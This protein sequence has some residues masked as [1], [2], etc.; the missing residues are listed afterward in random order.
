VKN[1]K[2]RVT[3]L[4]LLLVVT[5]FITISKV[6]ATTEFV[7]DVSDVW[8]NGRY[9]SVI[10][11]D[12]GTLYYA[13]QDLYGNLSG[14]GNYKTEFT[15]IN[16][17]D[18]FYGTGKE[19]I[20]YT[21]ANESRG[22]LLD[23]EGN[24]YYASTYDGV[25]YDR[26]FSYCVRKDNTNTCHSN[27]DNA[28]ILHPIL[29]KF[30]EEYGK[31]IIRIAGVR[32]A[33]IFETEDHV[34]WGIGN[35]SEE[36]VT[37][38][39]LGSG[40]VVLGSGNTIDKSETVNNKTVHD[41][42]MLVSNVQEWKIGFFD[43]A[44][45]KDA[46]SRLWFKANNKWYGVGSTYYNQLLTN[47][48]YVGFLSDSDFNGP[49]NNY[50]KYGRALDYSKINQ[51]YNKNYSDDN[52]VSIEGYG[53]STII[54]FDDGIA[55]H[56]GLPQYCNIADSAGSACLG[57][58][59]TN[60]IQVKM[61]ASQDYKDEIGQ[62][63]DKIVRTFPGAHAIFIQT[64]SGRIWARGSNDEGDLGFATDTNYTG[65][66]PYFTDISDVSRTGQ[67]L[68]VRI[69][70]TNGLKQQSPI[71]IMNPKK[72]IAAWNG[73]IA[74]RND[75]YLVGTARQGTSAYSGYY[76]A[77]KYEFDYDGFG[78]TR[79]KRANRI[80][81][82][83]TIIV[84]G[85]NN[86]TYW[87]ENPS[88]LQIGD[89]TE[90]VN[91]EDGKY[92]TYAQY[93]IYGCG[94]SVNNYTLKDISKCTYEV[95]TN[96]SNKSES[97]TYDS[98]IDDANKID[99]VNLYNVD[100][101]SLNLSPGYYKLVAKRYAFIGPDGTNG[102][103]PTSN[104]NA[105]KL[106]YN[107]SIG[108]K[109]YYFQFSVEP[110]IEAD[111][112]TLNVGDTFNEQDNVIATNSKGLN[113]SFGNNDYDLKVTSNNV[114]TNKVGV[115]FVSY[116]MKDEHVDKVVTKTIRVIV[117]DSN[118]IIS[119][120][121]L[122]QAH[123]YVLNKD[124]DVVN[125][126]NNEILNNAEA[127]A[128]LLSDGSSVDVKVIN[129]DNYHNEVN[130]YR[131]TI[132][133]KDDESITKTI[134]ASII[135]NDTT[136]KD[137]YAIKG[138]DFTI[139]SKNVGDSSDFYNEN[140]GN[141]KIWNIED[142]NDVVDITSP[143]NYDGYSKNENLYNAQF[144]IKNGT[145]NALNIKALV[146]D[147]ERFVDGNNYVI[148][149][150]NVVLSL[151]DAKNI[152]D[153]N[154]FISLSN[155]KA[156][157]KNDFSNGNIIVDT[158][159]SNFN[160][161]AGDYTITFIVQEE[162]TTK[163]SIN[164]KVLDYD[165][166]TSNDDY[167]L[168]ANDFDINV[169]RVAS[170][171]D[172]K[173]K[174]QSS[175][176]I[177]DK[178]FN[179]LNNEIN[180]SKNDIVAQVGGP[181]E[182]IFNIN[183]TNV[184]LSIMV[185]VVK[186]DN[187]VLNIPQY[188][189][190]MI[191]E[192]FDKFK[193]VSISDTEDGVISPN[194][195]NVNISGIIDTSKPGVSLLTYSFTDSDNNTVQATTLLIVD[196]GTFT[197]NDGYVLTAH[198]FII[199]K[200]DIS[201]D[202]NDIL[203][204]SQAHAYNLSDGHEVNVVVYNKNNYSN[205]TT[206]SEVNLILAVQ[207]NNNAKK[208][209]KAT[210]VDKDV[211]AVG[212]NYSIGANNIVIGKNDVNNLSDNELL[213]LM[214][215]EAWQVND[216]S[217]KGTVVIEDKDNIQ[218]IAGEYHF[219]LNVKEEATTKLN[220]TVEVSNKDNY[221]EDNG[222]IITSNDIVIGKK[223]VKKLDTD[224]KI[225][226]AI[227]A[228][229]IK[230]SDNSEQD[231]VILSDG[232]LSDLAM[233]YDITFALKDNQ[234]ITGVSAI[235]V[236]DYDHSF[237]N[238]NYQINAND[239]IKVNTT[240]VEDILNSNSEAK[241][242]NLSEAIAYKNRA[243]I[244]PTI[245][246]DYALLQAK[247]GTY[248]VKFYIDEDSNVYVIADVVVD[249][250]N[251][252]T[253]NVN[254]RD[255]IMV[256]SDYDPL[257]NVSVSDV[258]DSNINISD[259]KVTW[260]KPFNKDEVGLY[261]INYEVVDSDN[262]KAVA[263]RILCVNDGSIILG[264]D[265][266]LQA[267]DFEENKS[268]A[269][270]DANHI[271]NNSH[272]KAFKLSD[273][274]EEEV[275]V[276]D[277]GTYDD[278]KVGNHSLVLAIKDESST[279]KDINVVVFDSDNYV[280][281]DNY[282]IMGNNII[283]G[284]ND[285]SSISDD[286]IISYSKAK[287]W[288]NTHFNDNSLAID[289]DYHNLQAKAGTYDVI[290]AVHDH[291]DVK[292]TIKVT[293]LDKDIVNQGANYVISGDNAIIGKS[294][295]Q[296][297]SSDNDFILLN[298][299]EAFN[300]RD[301]NTKVDVFVDSNYFYNT[302]GTYEVKYCIKDE[303]STC[304]S[305]SIEVVDYDHAIA[306]DN[307]YLKANDV[308]INLGEVSGLTD[309]LFINKLVAD[310]NG[311]IKVSDLSNIQNSK[312]EYYVHIYLDEANNV[313]LKIKVN[314]TNGESP[315]LSFNSPVELKVNDNFDVMDGVSVS[316]KED[317]DAQL[318]NSVV[319]DKTSIDTSK[320]GL[321]ILNYSVIDSDFNEVKKP[322]VVLV[323]DGS[324]IVGDK[325]ILKAT[326]F[327]IN[328]K[329]VSLND[330]DIIKQASALGYTLAVD[331]VNGNEAKVIILDKNDYQ[332][333]P[334][335]YTI[336]FGV[337]DNSDIKASKDINATVIDKDYLVTGNS[338]MIAANDITLGLDDVDNLNEN[339]IIDLAQ[340][341]AWNKN[342]YQTKSDVIVN[343]IDVIKK[344]ATFDRPYLVTLAVK[345][346]TNTQ[347]VIKVHVINKDVVV[348]NHDY[349]ISGN[350][351]VIGKKDAENL[352]V[353]DLINMMNVEA[354][355]QKTNNNMDVVLITSSIDINK[356]NEKQ[357]IEFKIKDNDIK[358]TLNLLIIDND[359][360]VQYDNYLLVADD[361][362][363]RISQA[364]NI[365][366]ND[367]IQF[368]KAKV[369]DRNSLSECDNVIVNN[370]NI[371]NVKGTYDVNLGIN[372][373]PNSSLSIKAN[374][375]SGSAPTIDFNSPIILDVND[376]FDVYDG[377]MINDADE[378]L[379]N[380]NVDI[381]GD[382]VDTSMSGIYKILY[383]L[384]DSD[385]NI[386]S[387]PRLVIV[388]GNGIVINQHYVLEAHS[389]IINAN[390]FSDDDASII[391]SSKAKAYNIDDLTSADIIVL[392]KNNYSAVSGKYPLKLAVK[393]D[394]SLIRDI[395]ALV[396]ANDNYYESS[397]YVITSNDVI[398]GLKT[399]HSIKN[400]QDLIDITNAQAFNKK[401]LNN[402]IVSVAS[403]DF[404]DVSGNYDVV[405][406]VDKEP[407]STINSK[408]R[409]IDK[410][411]VVVNNDYGIEGNDIT[412]GTKDAK[413][414]IDN[415]EVENK[416]IALAKARAWL[417]SDYDT[418]LSSLAIKDC[419]LE[420][421][422]GTY[423]A[424]VYLEDKVSMTININVIKDDYYYQ[425][426]AYTIIGNDFTINETVAKNITRDEII[427]LAKAKTY[428]NSDNNQLGSVKVLNN[429][430]KNQKE[431]TYQVKLYCDEEIDTFIIINVTI[432]NGQKPLLNISPEFE[433]VP[434]NTSNYDV[435]NG[436]SASDPD[437]ASINEN[438]VVIKGSVDTSQ[439]GIY[440]IN[441]SLT[442][443]DFNIVNKTRVVLV[444]DGSYIIGQNYIIK[445]HDFEI[446]KKYV[447][448]DL[449]SII[450]ASE[451]EAYSKL[452]GSKATVMV[453]DDDSY[454][455]KEIKTYHIKLAV[456]E[457]D[458]LTTSINATIFNKDNSHVNSSYSI[459]GN[460][461]VLAQDE[462]KNLTKEKLIDKAQLEQWDTG[463]YISTRDNNVVISDRE[464]DKINAQPNTYNIS[465]AHQKNNGI[466]ITIKVKV[467][468][469][470]VV[471]YDENYLIS[472]N[473]LVL[474]KKQALAISDMNEFISLMNV[475]GFDNKD[476]NVD[477]EVVTALNEFD[478][479]KNVQEIEFKVKDVI[480]PTIKVK[481]TILDYDY[482]QENNG[483]IIA[484]ND[485]SIRKS[486]VNNLDIVSKAKATIFEK[487][488]LTKPSTNYQVEIKQGQVNTDIKDYAI[489]LGIKD[490][491]EPTLTINVS[492]GAGQIPDLNVSPLVIINKDKNET[493]QENDISVSDQE[494][495]TNLN[496]IAS[497][498]NVNNQ[499]IGIYFRYYSVTDSDNNSV[500][501][502]RMIVVNDDKN[503]IIVDENKGYVLKADNYV[504]NSKDVIDN[505]FSQIITLSNAIAY[506]ISDAKQV[507]VIVSNSDNYNKNVGLYQ[508]IIA[509]KD[510]TSI[511]KK[512]NINVLNK[513]IIQNGNVYAIGAK[514]IKI[515]KEKARVLA[516]DNNKLIEALHAEAWQIKDYNQKGTV[517]VT[518]T[519]NLQ[520][521]VG[522]YDITLK[523]KEDSV[524]IQ[525]K[526]IVVDYDIYEYDDEYELMA[527]NIVIG[528]EDAKNISDNK[529]LLSLAD[530]KAIKL[531]DNSKA[532]VELD[533]TNFQSDKGSYQ[534]QISVKE[535]N[536]IKT[537]L[538][539]EV[540]DN[541]HAQKGNNYVIVGNDFTINTTK[542]S[543]IT[544]DEI[545][546]LAKANGYLANDVNQ[547]GNVIVI[548]NAI[549]GQEG[550]FSVVLGLQ[551]DNKALITIN[552][553]VTNGKAPILEVNNPIELKVN[554][555]FN[556]KNTITKLED[557]KDQLNKN[558][559]VI[560]GNV[561]TKV[562]GIY[563]LTY[564]VSDSDYNVTEVKQ[565]VI[566]ND[567][568]YLI[569]D[570]YV[571][572]ACDFSEYVDNTELSEN[573][574]LKE[575]K[576]YGYDIKNNK[577]VSVILYNINDYQAKAGKYTIELAL[578]N[579]NDVRKSQ[580]I[581]VKDLPQAVL[582]NVKDNY[583]LIKDH[584]F[585]L[586][587][588]NDDNVNI[589]LNS[590]N[591]DI[592]SVDNTGV[593]KGLNKGTSIIKIIVSTRDGLKETS[594]EV[595]I[596]VGLMFEPEVDYNNEEAIDA[597]N[598][599]LTLSETKDL[600][601]KLLINK[602]HASAW[603][604]NK[605]TLNDDIKVVVNNHK[606]KSKLSWDG[607][608]ALLSSETKDINRGYVYPITF[609][610]NKGT[611][612]TIYARVVPDQDNESSSE[613]I[614][615]NKNSNKGKK[616]IVNTGS[617]YLLIA[618]SLLVVSE[619]TYL[620]YTRQSK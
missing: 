373:I 354:I 607:K 261:R 221:L 510:D 63:W 242:I 422:E 136:I 549:V 220:I 297:L 382:T 528:K 128:F 427:N 416:I 359:Y 202:D 256:G 205:V 7:G 48:S 555:S 597:S 474:G 335:T 577:E 401:T 40:S 531:T 435:K 216:Y 212:N 121:Y 112:V 147:N 454:F 457:E 69:R 592:V 586:D 328:K 550:Q 123:S 470:D 563:V 296:E 350:N 206:A 70:I 144:N 589:K 190:I 527:N 277:Y 149:A 542:A 385:G 613:V 357:G 421:K 462:V 596:N 272:A 263:S 142:P 523:V 330:E 37:D 346:E 405:F 546:N 513:D 543:N 579:N 153:L 526:V 2:R 448:N 453:K 424:T 355:E 406:K 319:V 367:I 132:A 445:A 119:D 430:I 307:Y 89:K 90:W 594:K 143:N 620:C 31:K 461:V 104:V 617:N 541:D 331:K 11:T 487:D 155:A 36:D 352:N 233:P 343:N 284:K 187:P 109:E 517:E 29:A 336:K 391:S 166:I 329:D 179:K 163:I 458:T 122:L 486:Q 446:N 9:G 76:G 459:G 384:T 525:V 45:N 399:A 423:Q 199:N 270:K 222:Y 558:D 455:S 238:D 378:V 425:G 262:N 529:M 397:N 309:E 126:G 50:G 3:L 432:S 434:L 512:I 479:N 326:D 229:I 351:L 84:D 38:N 578:K 475:E 593:I 460:N 308:E 464:F 392:D 65:N 561:D 362:S 215:A 316:D 439:A 349:L 177:F 51:T 506:R 320:A 81:K 314:V 175:V 303:A 511:N 15:K 1:N 524:S 341:E 248:Q 198:N 618:L 473:N 540:K 162:T 292:I 91:K 565:V 533:K 490:N 440:V 157:N 32:S 251:T 403:S 211:M 467:I 114:N 288:Q 497:G 148:A 581:I 363:L 276:K 280:S 575:S 573:H 217:A 252:P 374:V 54:V 231:K 108:D 364:K 588:I 426:N 181:Y 493:Y 615:N 4:M 485:F 228:S 339:K 174:S 301:V 602:A 204:K 87:E 500:N 476:N 273:F 67:Q 27:S 380:N 146:L 161:I 325:Y 535:K 411:N 387:K 321:Y 25:D 413:T 317:D 257:S 172:N 118:S 92:P 505:D 518:N 441:Y 26:S 71:E 389:Y 450:V 97:R 383:T 279:T 18:Q 353:N 75:E 105:G 253:L 532:N 562:A 345:D 340:A 488:N 154:E 551:E 60:P 260:D 377:V 417:K 223:D 516:H 381:T 295:A 265:Y 299:V 83:P 332:A 365:S 259:I 587:F 197:I 188:T 110:K 151:S 225:L 86:P 598:V 183:N 213:T 255:N 482:V 249:N 545:I 5:G 98:S 159:N 125:G 285:V 49:T 408:V 133:I 127:K 274:S 130:Q 72:L 298:K 492:V 610:T 489:E 442:D 140:Y 19:I 116:E 337:E 160:S 576:A 195:N 498:D 544:N 106:Q 443:K 13:G 185:N 369:L 224:D 237:S 39:I 200:K 28:Y 400:D 519:S 452:D 33:L 184:N 171:N 582:N 322:R 372:S 131:P 444:N 300:N 436:L 418:S 396:I 156:K 30:K 21:Y 433:E 451:A 191:N 245:K 522:D 437:D 100:L 120:D 539:I 466:T 548:S 82:N 12:D 605:Q 393:D 567:G 78:F 79:I 226:Q 124:I 214:N 520:A 428:L 574:I 247:E 402:E 508:P 501:K 302:V 419:T 465:V 468:A 101:S 14:T 52:V 456:K 312:G 227:D 164:V 283:I 478:V 44:E 244:N 608:K 614:T 496:I 407:S 68:A 88:N 404:K 73:T 278:N 168:A 306:L 134:V 103:Y 192:S 254:E 115:Y 203:N 287:A 47:K 281:D 509:L 169:G 560:S 194:D 113:V 264:N 46:S 64:E 347:L 208:I 376:N 360:V 158:N 414:M 585:N 334:G 24:V 606:I 16:F 291:S 375:I 568:N 240:Q 604:I 564:Q 85:N 219:V 611:N 447:V 22:F 20:Q 503:S 556:P 182:V 595:I 420:A 348:D 484:A 180:V 566:V 554:D 57:A 371:V 235:T 167:Y 269:S 141:L 201:N 483:L 600:N 499:E 571:I 170:L 327:V 502:T 388:K 538:S 232:G 412:L 557:D 361:F 293:V 196:D 313:K 268:T 410:D 547:K 139:L 333:A 34:L 246:V 117:K 267:Y 537:N 209:I 599:E 304:L 449:D 310:T 386:A 534:A 552:V 394:T 107:S 438:N 530:A 591:E 480:R 218:P 129:N 241:L 342:N 612:I 572:K 289:V 463:S 398:M 56:V 491:N 305:L 390:N 43:Y 536:S 590:S 504:I 8:M 55:Y 603:S 324:Y 95:K 570:N 583:N 234:S 266:A 186:G 193:N 472:G 495:G 584:E 494:D 469:K 93:T 431:G 318:L 178:N 41:V 80:V 42:K 601:E 409:V 315:I 415:N 553:I 294:K 282:S 150:D 23:N 207:D 323:N 96:N 243:S 286:M 135:D 471:S 609:S 10:K 239:I 275:I 189:K 514:S 152:S 66:T 580:T 230:I 395:D 165:H 62:G 338:Y 99:D 210:I 58:A 616:I 61:F 176:T 515:G 17:K 569:K 311:T 368:S 35:S 559:V 53:S 481:L 379:T 358:I 258:E 137:D 344:Q 290:L 429:T 145:L 507:E 94:T 356:I 477:V 77:P 236:I 138:K 59:T 271:I 370:H 366:D 6:D 521:Q 619:I 173:I 74:L 250:G 111:N 102:A